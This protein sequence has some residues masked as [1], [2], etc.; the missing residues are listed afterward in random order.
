MQYPVSHLRWLLAF[1]A[2]AR[3]GQ[4]P[5][6]PPPAAPPPPGYKTAPPDGPPP[7]R[8]GT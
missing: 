5:P 6:P 7:A 2:R 3:R 8:E 4:T 1:G